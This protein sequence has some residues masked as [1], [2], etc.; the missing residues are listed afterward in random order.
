MGLSVLLN[1]MAEDYY[2]SHYSSY[3]FRVLLHDAYDFPDRN[4]PTKIVTL[5]KESFMRIV[6][7][8]TYSTEDIRNMP[9]DMRKCLFH[10]E[11]KMPVMQRYSFVNC[12]S[13]CRIRLLYEKCGCITYNL[14]NNGS[15][16]TC[17][18]KELGCVLDNR[19]EH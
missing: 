5:G 7:E 10:D 14:P 3:G 13:N 16:K 18:L 11:H 2:I 8:I 15:A 4:A 17:G 9:I 19:G 12:M 1:P 6:P